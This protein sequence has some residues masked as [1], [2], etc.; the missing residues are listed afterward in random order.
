MYLP[1]LP[2]YFYFKLPLTLKTLLLVMFGKHIDFIR[3]PGDVLCVFPT[4]WR[5]VQVW[6]VLERLPPTRCW[7][8]RC[9]LPTWPWWAPGATRPGPESE[10]WTGECPGFCGCLS[11]QCR[12]GLRGSDW[13]SLGLEETYRHVNRQFQC[14]LKLIW[15]LL[16]TVIS[17]TVW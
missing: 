13:P 12:S 1:S 4:C 2:F 7:R 8:A 9:R 14:F 16:D 15:L 11:T 3:L 6:G 17:R 10:P 5:L